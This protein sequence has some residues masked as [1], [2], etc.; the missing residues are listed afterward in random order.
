VGLAFGVGFAALGIGLIVDARRVYENDKNGRLYN[1]TGPR[2][3]TAGGVVSLVV[4]AA[5]MT[6]P[7]IDL[8]RTVAAPSKDTVDTI[9]E[10]GPATE[11]GIPCGADMPAAG[12]RVTAHVGST[13]FDLG[14][15]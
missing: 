6:A 9:K 11:R 12:E 15:T 8:G 1:S 3:A 4:G 13:S 14:T 2:G 7:V 5:I 10:T